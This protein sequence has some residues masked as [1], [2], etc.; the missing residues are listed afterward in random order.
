MNSKIYTVLLLITVLFYSC[1]N[2]HKSKAVLLDYSLG[3]GWGY[4]YSIKV[5]N[6]GTAYLKKNSLKK[7]DSLWVKQNLNIDTLSA[8]IL[9]AKEMK[10][11]SKYE[12]QNIQDASFF[13]VTLYYN[14]GKTSNHYVYGN[15]YPVL[16]GK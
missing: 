12:Q 10:L 5:Y 11:A 16:L 3:S 14:D 1:K 6:D 13:Y 7:A 4:S 2:N 15:K 8:I 9:K